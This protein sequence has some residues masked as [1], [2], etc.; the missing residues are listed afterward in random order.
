[1]ATMMAMDVDD[2]NDKGGNASL[3]MC[4][5]GYNCNCYEGKDACAST[6]TTPAHW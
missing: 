3:T 5:E 2:N 4:N 6:A 1:M